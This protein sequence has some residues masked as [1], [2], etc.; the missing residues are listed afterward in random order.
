MRICQRYDNVKP[1]IASTGW[2][3]KFTKRYNFH[4]IKMTGEPV[5]TD[6][7]AAEKLVREMQHIIEEGYYAPKQIFNINETAVY[8]K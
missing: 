7:V 5:F 8:W 2:F 4:N 6:T 1:F 3:S